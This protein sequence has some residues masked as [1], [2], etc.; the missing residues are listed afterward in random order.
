MPLPGPGIYGNAASGPIVLGDTVLVQDLSSTLRAID[1]ATGKVR[2]TRTYDRLNIGPNGP[3]AGYGFVYAAKGPTEIAAVDLKTGKEAWSTK[4]VTTATE[5]IDIQPQVYGGLVF[6]S[7]V[8]ISLQG[9]YNPG[10]R[11]ILYALDA[12]TGD[13]RWT[14][15]TV[16]G[17]DLWGD[18]ST[19]SGGGAWYPPTVD[20]DTGTIYF[21]IANPAPYPG[22]PEA[23]NGA[24]RPGPNLYT[25]SVVALDAA[26]GKLRWFH[27]AVEHDLF[28]RDLVHTMVVETG[29]AKRPKV[30]IGTGKLGRIIGLDPTTGKE[31]FDTEVGT[32]HNDELTKLDGPTSVTPGSYGGVLTPPA[33]ADGVVYAAVIN[34]PS[35]FRPDED[36]YIGAEL[37]QVPGTM[38]AVDATDGKVLWSTAIDGDPLG[39]TT[40][41]GDL[42]FTGTQTG[43]LLAFDRA[44]GE[45][46]WRKQAPG[47]LNGWPA[48]V[49]DT[50]LWPVGSAKPPQLVAYRLS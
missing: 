8:P 13:I 22:T 48:V 50:L 1:L 36:A 41:A 5:G 17:D 31:R 34:A 39:G 33:A 44:T 26:T 11:G 16:K 2:W 35:T 28:D 9:Q 19:N 46:V 15:D 18:P 27:Q 47:G 14:F 10:D 20:E 12:K 3:A 6:A 4:L 43:L 7:T 42:V 24:S 23:P 37:G 21:G 32:H 30:V 25:D 45:E 38:V 29:D 40:V 49:G